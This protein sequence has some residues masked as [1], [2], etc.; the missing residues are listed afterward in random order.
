M[1]R[2]RLS[3]ADR[4]FWTL[5][6]RAAFANPFSDERAEI[7]RKIAGVNRPLSN[8][9][10]FRLLTPKLQGELRKLESSGMG[11]VCDHGEDDREVFETAFL[12]LLY[13]EHAADLDASIQNQ[14]RAGDEPVAIPFA[15]ALLGQ[16]QRFGFALE[17]ALRH[18]ALLFQLRRAYHFIGENLAGKSASMKELRRRLWQNVVTHDIRLYA[19][20]LMDRMEDFSTLLLGET[21]TGKGTAAAAIGRSGPIPFDDKR[22]RFVE[23]FTRA[24]VALNLSRFP[25]A[26][27]ESA[28]F[29]H[30]KGAFTGAVE[31]HDGIF[32]R[33]S[34]HGAIF[35]DEIGEVSGPVQIKLLE[36]LQER[37]FSAV[38][39]QELQRFRGRVVAATNRP[40][41]DL[42][43]STFRDDFF[44]RLS[45]DIIRVPPLRQR[46]EEEPEEL[47]T[48]LSHVLRRTVGRDAPELVDLVRDV[49]AAELPARYPWPG[50]VRELEQATRRILLTRSY[51]GEQLEVKSSDGAKKVIQAFETGEINAHGLLAAYCCHLY[52]RHGNLAEVARRTGLDRRTV[53]KHV[54]AEG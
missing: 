42:R 45:S 15:R 9:E 51:H 40:L 4:E 28:L 33:C 54:R 43:E 29:G 18:V 32:A 52:N 53:K 38:G 35:L 47:D 5:V 31:S 3:A 8:E 34:P 24:F 37:I 11:R 13:H 10:R 1:P 49:L 20:H 44:Y 6:A 22:G 48:L 26:L 21:G 23:S 50:N 17:E 41:A 36:V 14:I 27:L 46:L 30:R 25:E 2:S 16:M 19:R 7:D 12:F 39:S